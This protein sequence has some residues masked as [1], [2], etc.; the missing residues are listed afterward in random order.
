MWRQHLCDARGLRLTRALHWTRRVQQPTLS[1]MRL[2]ILIRAV[3]LCLCALP[4]GAQDVRGVIFD[5]LLT[6]APLASARV[7]LEPGALQATTDRRGRFRFPQVSAGEYQLTFFHP[8]LDSIR[9]AA[10]VFRLV[11][12][13]T[14]VRSVEL[15]TPSY[16]STARF[17]CGTELDEASTIVLG[18]ARAAETGERLVGAEALVRWWEFTLGEGAAARYTPRELRAETDSAGRFLLCG[19]PTDI[20]M[21]MT[22]RHGRQ[23]TG[24]L[25]FPPGTRAISLRDVTVSLA[26]TAATINEDSTALDTLPRAG[27]ARV[28]VTVVDERGRPVRRATVGVRGHAASGT[29]NDAGQAL[30]VGVPAGSQSIVVRAIGRTP[31]VLLANLVPGSE[32]ALRLSMAD[33]AALLPDYRVAGI[34]RN[35]EREAYDRRRRAG[36]GR[37]FDADDLDKI[38][39]YV[40]RLQVIPGVR[41]SGVGNGAMVLLRSN[42]MDLCVPTVWIDGIPRLRMD[43]WELSHWLTVAKRMEVYTR[44]INVPA[45]FA[46]AFNNCGTLVIWTN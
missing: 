9:V 16:A 40:G 18:S 19:V 20:E 7:V 27:A 44:P 33:V 24:P 3:L 34:P 41:T 15:A 45:E 6:R 13:S 5:S 4:A 30:L 37:F 17:V 32:S 38:G 22:V 12:P 1:P 42:A 2:L 8:S 28:R 10:P 25:V 26:D 14:G 31:A 46:N 23:S 36:S 11:V 35:L 39:R 29:T 21:T 43:G